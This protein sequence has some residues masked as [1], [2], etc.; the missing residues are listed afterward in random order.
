MQQNNS[1]CSDQDDSESSPRLEIQVGHLAGMEVGHRLAREEGRGARGTELDPA[2]L[3]QEAA[4]DPLGRR[5][6]LNAL[7]LGCTCTEHEPTGSGLLVP[8]GL[9]AQPPPS[10]HAPINNQTRC[11]PSPLQ[12]PAHRPRAPACCPPSPSSPQWRTCKADGNRVRVSLQDRRQQGE[13][14]GVVQTGKYAQMRTSLC[15]PP[16]R[17]GSPAGSEHNAPLKPGGCLV[18]PGLHTQP[19]PSIHAQDI[20][21]LS[22]FLSFVSLT[23]GSCPIRTP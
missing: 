23:P 18:P 19:A 10:I 7:S 3:E 16:P 1:A 11:P 15:C 9:H 4:L 6:R 21:C 5:S 22:V 12:Y 17:N 13:H 8:P 2:P 20:L 14:R